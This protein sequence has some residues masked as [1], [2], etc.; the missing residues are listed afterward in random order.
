MPQSIFLHGVLT[1]A[2]VVWC[3]CMQL[4]ELIY[5]IT[6]IFIFILTDREW[7]IQGLVLMYQCYIGL[8]ITSCELSEASMAWQTGYSMNKPILILFTLFKSFLNWDGRIVIF[9]W[10]P[11][12][13]NSRL[14]FSQF[15]I[16]ILIS[17]VT[18]PLVYTYKN[19]SESCPVL[20]FSV[21]FNMQSCQIIKSLLIHQIPIVQCHSQF[22]I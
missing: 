15:Q 19:Y 17:N 3:K 20:Y 16:R 21:I 2:T 7:P 5:S 6:C 12:L 18:L 14:I 13:V 1:V 11:D 8:S 9:C 22:K 4:E 10:I